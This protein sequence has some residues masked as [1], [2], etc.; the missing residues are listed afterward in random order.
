MILTLVYQDSTESLILAIFLNFIKNLESCMFSSM[1]TVEIHLFSL[2]NRV[3]ARIFVSRAIH[4]STV[5][6]SKV[7]DPPPWLK[8]RRQMTLGHIR[9]QMGLNIN[10]IPGPSSGVRKSSLLG[11][12]DRAGARS[13]LSRPFAIAIVLLL[14]TNA[15]P[16]RDHPDQ[17]G[18]I[19]LDAIWLGR[20]ATMVVVLDFELMR[21]QDWFLTR[22]YDSTSPWIQLGQYLLP[23]RI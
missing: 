23:W 8:W 19:A 1:K 18:C 11:S 5:V 6:L 16:F 20:S 4:D 2:S 14:K 7:P 3:F 9:A 10:L 15:G 21:A 12:I 17:K 22:D 13:Q